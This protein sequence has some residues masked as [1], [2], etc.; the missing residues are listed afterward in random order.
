[1]ITSGASLKTTAPSQPI[2]LTMRNLLVQLGVPAERIVADTAALDTH[3]EALAVAAL[4]QTLRFER[5]ILV[6]S[7]VH[8]RRAA[9]VFRAV[10]VQPIPAIARE[11]FPPR[12]LRDWVLP[13]EDGLWSARLLAHE[14][15]GIGYYA[16]RGWYR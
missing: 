10:G 2:G 6:T 11:P 4:A 16:A 1:V 14:L 5:L 7:E 8:M 12:S 3:D 13:S 9:G 15:L